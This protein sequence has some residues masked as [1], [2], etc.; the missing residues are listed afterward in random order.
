MGRGTGEEQWGIRR[1]AP[2]VAL[3][4]LPSN[5]VSK[6]IQMSFAPG[7][8]EVGG[9]FGR[10]AGKGT[11]SPRK[12]FLS[13]TSLR[14]TSSF[15]ENVT[16]KGRPWWWSRTQT[17]NHNVVRLILRLYPYHSSCVSSF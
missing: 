10:G 7:G 16:I 8:S 11:I 6:R 9:R 4:S 14:V 13:L 5:A 3:L 15:A 12:K 17:M 1:G 2:N